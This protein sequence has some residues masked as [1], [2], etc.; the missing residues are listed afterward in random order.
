MMKSH[1]QPAMPPT[2]ERFL[3]AAACKYPLNIEPILFPINQQLLVLGCRVEISRS[4]LER[5]R[6]DGPCSFEELQG[7]E[8]ARS[9]VLA[10]RIGI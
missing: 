3:Y 2:P 1:L 4:Q 10:S 6:K 9:S 8:G 7:Q 5:R